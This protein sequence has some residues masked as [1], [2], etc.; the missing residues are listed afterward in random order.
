MKDVS[1]RI[2]VQE[3]EK[4]VIRA[5]KE[6]VEGMG[7]NGKAGGADARI[8]HTDKDGSFGEVAKTGG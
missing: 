8:H 3:P 2:F 6:G 1:V 5:D 4:A 7:Q